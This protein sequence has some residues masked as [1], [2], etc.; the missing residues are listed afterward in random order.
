MNF[1]YALAA[2]PERLSFANNGRTKDSSASDEPCVDPKATPTSPERIAAS[3]SPA[4]VIASSA[5]CIA[6]RPRRPTVRVSLR[7]QRSRSTSVTGAPRRVRRSPTRSQ[8]FMR[9]TPERPSRSA[10]ESA[11][12]ELP[13]GV[14]TPTPVMT[15][16]RLTRAPASR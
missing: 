7:G 1:R 11:S 13:T 16:R 10:A 14:A 15:T 4:E 3:S 8:S 5:A 2:S 9:T 6:S 12:R